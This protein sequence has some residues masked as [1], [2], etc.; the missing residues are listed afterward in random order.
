MEK[1]ERPESLPSS[2]RFAFE[3]E[4]ES[5]YDVL[6]VDDVAMAFDK[7][8]FDSV[9][10][11]VKKGERVALLG[12]NGVGKT[13][14]FHLILKDYLPVHGRIRLGSKVMI[15]YYDQEQTSLSPEKQSLMK[16]MMLILI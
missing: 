5:G 9:S 2:I 10:F 14:M 15:G 16:Y 13:T 3:P 11:E 8:L 4:V 6:K 1:V 7:P 12:P